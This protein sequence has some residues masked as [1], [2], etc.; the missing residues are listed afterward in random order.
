M[1]FLQKTEIAIRLGTKFWL[2]DMGL[3]RV[4]SFWAYVLLYL[5][6]NY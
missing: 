3:E 6:F 2:G 4:T 1:T 5:I